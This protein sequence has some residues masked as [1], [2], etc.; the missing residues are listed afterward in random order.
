MHNVFWWNLSSLAPHRSTPNSHLHAF[1]NSPSPVGA[2]YVVM[3]VGPPIEWW[4]SSPGAHPRRRE[5]R[6]L[7]TVTQTFTF[8]HQKLIHTF[9][10]G[11]LPH[12]FASRR[13]PWS[14]HFRSNLISK[15]ACSLLQRPDEPRLWCQETFSWWLSNLMLTFLSR[16]LCFKNQFWHLLL[17]TLTVY[18]LYG[19]L[20]SP[21]VIFPLILIRDRLCKTS[22]FSCCWIH[23]FYLMR[24]LDSLSCFFM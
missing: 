17:G 21:S 20:F 2:A 15:M 18:Q 7:S 6:A 11:F 19:K 9:L 24:P 3:A 13:P 16:C 22:L 5:V 14:N 23:A 1:Y 8:H 12:I 10:S 4:S